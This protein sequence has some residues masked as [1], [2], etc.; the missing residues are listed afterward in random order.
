MFKIPPVYR[1]YFTSLS[2][3]EVQDRTLIDAE[4]DDNALLAAEQLLAL[5]SVS[6]GTLWADDRLLRQFVS[7][8]SKALAVV[9]SR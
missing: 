9:P 4:D 3:L 1:L 8:S 5:S 7:T 6:A 2:G